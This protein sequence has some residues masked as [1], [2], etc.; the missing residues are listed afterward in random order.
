LATILTPQDNGNMFQ[1]QWS[2]METGKWTNGVLFGQLGSYVVTLTSGLGISVASGKAVVQGFLAR[3]D[4]G[5]ALA[6]AAA[7]PTNPRI[8]RVVLHADLTAHTLTV[9]M[10]TG[11][12]APSPVPPALTQT[13]TVWEVSL[14]QVRVNATQTTLTGGSLTDERTYSAPNTPLAI[15]YV[16]P[17]VQ[18]L[19]PQSGAA[20]WH[21]FI[22]WNGSLQK[23]PFGIGFGAAGIA[24]AW[25]DDNGVFNS[26]QRIGAAGI[27]GQPTAG[28]FGVPLIVAQV[29]HAN[30]TVTTLLTLLTYA[31][32]ASGLY[33]ISGMV[34]G[35]NGGTFKPG[36]F[37]SVQG[38]DDAGAFN[39][40]LTNATGVQLNGVNIFVNLISQPLIATTF[41]AKTGTN[42]VITYQDNAGTPNDFVTVVIERVA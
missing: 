14:Y 22:T 13:S 20:N 27:G 37:A 3:S 12:P 17:A 40:S 25:I 1:A 34:F 11:T 26:S 21:E 23:I 28:S 8:D 16:P 41:S 6:C 31:V 33:R 15:A 19:T 35:N 36:L 30:V 10:L 2:E 5:V 29:L 7:D 38:I 39:F 42:M 18:H 32:P 9:Q 24:N 4:A